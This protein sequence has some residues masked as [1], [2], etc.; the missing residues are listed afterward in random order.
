MII[1]IA[2]K[3]FLEAFENI[4]YGSINIKMPNGKVYGYQGKQTGPHGEMIIHDTSMIIN[5][6]VRGDIGFLMI[7]AV[8]NGTAPI[9]LH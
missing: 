3:K 1:D 5:L 7:T 9:W 4:E 6:Y 2:E 8:A